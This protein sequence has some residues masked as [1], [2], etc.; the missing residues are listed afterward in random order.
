MSITLSQAIKLLKQ[1]ELLTWALSGPYKAGSIQL[2]TA[3]QR[4]L[5]NFLAENN[6]DAVASADDG[7]FENLTFGSIA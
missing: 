5:F 7:I 1:G 4:R 6:I 3:G 2:N